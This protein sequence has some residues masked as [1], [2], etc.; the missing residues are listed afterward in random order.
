M[1]ELLET[2]A[3]TGQWSLDPARSTVSLRNRAMWGL[4][5]V[6]GTFGQISGHGTVSPDGDVTGALTIAAAS[7]DTK[8]ARRDRHLR[9]ADFFDTE[10]HADITFTVDGV[11]PARQAVTFLGTLTVRGRTKPMTFEGTAA[12]RGDTEVWLDAVVHVN[13]IDFGLT[14]NWLGTVGRDNVVTVR[15]VFTRGPRH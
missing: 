12:A 6:N 3:L 9:S 4:A 11:R 1:T 15:A 13:Q 14:W 10:N 8:N 2:S 5:P 7:I